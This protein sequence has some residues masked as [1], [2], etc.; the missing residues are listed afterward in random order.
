MAVKQEQLKD[1]ALRLAGAWH[2]RRI[3]AEGSPVWQKTLETLKSDVDGFFESSESEVLTFALL[4]EGVAV[5]G[6]PI[7]NAPG[8]VGR[9]AAQL[10][11]RDIEIISLQRE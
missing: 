8:T 9:L 3:Y 1:L 6:V 2:S 4:G 11:A 10:K 5:S 7:I